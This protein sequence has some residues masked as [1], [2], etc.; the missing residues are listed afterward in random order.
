MNENKLF[1]LA[2][3]LDLI[4]DNSFPIFPGYGIVNTKKLEKIRQE[5]PTA[6]INEITDM[7]T[8]K[9]KKERIL[10]EAKEEAARIIREA[11]NKTDL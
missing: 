2:E 7:R 11:K 10:Q 5:L 8:I 3:E 1:D 4:L 9:I 6:L